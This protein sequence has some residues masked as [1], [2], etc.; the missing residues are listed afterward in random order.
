MIAS[1]TLAGRVVAGAARAIASASA[2]IATGSST[3]R[4]IWAKP[5]PVA[6]V[7]GE[8]LEGKRRI[9]R[10]I[11]RKAKQDAEYLDYASL[12][13]SKILINQVRPPIISMDD[14]MQAELEQVYRAEMM[15]AIS[16]AIRQREQDEEESLLAL[17]L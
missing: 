15:Q 11:K 10:A 12:E 17:L 6:T 13:Y 9:I 16:A 14:M 1:S 2:G 5:K 7:A 4:R 8:P 3:P